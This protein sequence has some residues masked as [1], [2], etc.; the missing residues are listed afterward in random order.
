MTRKL[1][2]ISTLLAL[3][4]TLACAD[5]PCA[6]VEGP[7]LYA[8]DDTVDHRLEGTNPLA[9]DSI[10]DAVQAATPGTTVCVSAGI[11]QEEIHIEKP[12]IS[13][14]GAGPERTIIEPRHPN[15]DP[16]DSEATLLRVSSTGIV[17]EGLQLRGGS[18]G[19]ALDAGSETQLE[20]IEL[21]TNT[22]GIRSTDANSLTGKGVSLIRNTTIGALLEQSS[23]DAPAFSLMDLRV[24]GN[25]QRGVSSVGGIRSEHPLILTRAHFQDNTGT[26]AGDLSV[27][28]L[29]AMDL[30]VSQPYSADKAPRMILRGETFIQEA[31]IHVLG[32]GLQIDCE[33]QEISMVN[34]AISDGDTQL[35]AGALLSVNDCSGTFQHLTLAKL[36]GE[37]RG[38]GLSL[39]GESEV[40]VENSAFVHFNEAISWDSPEPRAENNFEGTLQEAAL[41]SPLGAQPNLR[42]QRDSPLVDGALDRGVQRDLEGWNRPL[43]GAPDIGAYERL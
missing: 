3:T 4:T 25:G 34:T 21:R 27:T 13:L 30:R 24:E 19:L 22:I 43:G 7:V 41:L 6:G 40:L 14:R 1:P 5:G 26:D 33:G 12:G 18:T 29:D 35:D 37:Q 39:L 32:G 16:R 9:Y 36:V 28:G 2:L 20:D 38:S 31:L 8:W 11:W 23:S 10:E 15:S 42:P 17:L